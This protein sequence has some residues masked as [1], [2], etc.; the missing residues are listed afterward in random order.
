M[1]EVTCC[2]AIVTASRATR[3]VSRNRGSADK[4]RQTSAK[5]IIKDTWI[6]A[7]GNIKLTERASSTK[8]AAKQVWDYE[9]R[10]N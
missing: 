10:V 6:S 1:S 4:Q 5:R 2:P 8:D 3:L 7:E 9:I